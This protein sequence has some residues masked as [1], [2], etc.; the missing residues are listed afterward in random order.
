MPADVGS[1]R[2][3]TQSCGCMYPEYSRPHSMW[4][5]VGELKSI[6]LHLL[7]YLLVKKTT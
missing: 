4:F 3:G 1:T 2:K 7:G 5:E 6:I